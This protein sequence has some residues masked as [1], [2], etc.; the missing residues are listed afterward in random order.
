MCHTLLRPK[1][2]FTNYLLIFINNYIDIFKVRY[3]IKSKPE[4]YKVSPKL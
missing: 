4:F 2:Y 3:F 1:L